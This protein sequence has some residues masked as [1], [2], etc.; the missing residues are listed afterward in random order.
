MTP[1]VVAIATQP[2]ADD[3][4]RDHSR[5]HIFYNQHI[6]GNHSN[7]AKVVDPGIIRR[8]TLLSKIK[9]SQDM[10]THAE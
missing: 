6:N 4:L 5:I 2:Q 9:V 3:Q 1:S 7:I 10:K 8:S